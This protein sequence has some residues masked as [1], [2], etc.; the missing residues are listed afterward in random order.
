[1]GIAEAI[2]IT[3]MVTAKNFPIAASPLPVTARA[4]VDRYD[5]ALALVL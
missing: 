4:P 2:A 1:M 3:M 5:L